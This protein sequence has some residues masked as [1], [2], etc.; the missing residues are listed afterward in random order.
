MVYHK[1]SKRS[2]TYYLDREAEATSHEY[3]SIRVLVRRN[4]MKYNGVESHHNIIIWKINIIILSLS[5]QHTNT[6]ILF[7]IIIILISQLDLSHLYFSEKREREK[8]IRSARARKRE[9]LKLEIYSKTIIKRKKNYKIKQPK[10]LKII[11]I[12][13][14]K[15][16]S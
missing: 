16:S 1:I 13:G 2:M 3:L 7:Q 4:E 14:L 15:S 8:K 11:Y 5:T 10:R 6:H 9:L 12:P